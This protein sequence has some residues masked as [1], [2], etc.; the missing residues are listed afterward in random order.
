M[1]AVSVVGMDPVG[2]IQKIYVYFSFLLITHL[3]AL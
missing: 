3:L 2:L 1:R